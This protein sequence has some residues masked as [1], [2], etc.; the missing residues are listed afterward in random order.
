MAVDS[1]WMTGQAQLLEMPDCEAKVSVEHPCSRSS[2]NRSG[3]RS[4]KHSTETRQASRILPTKIS[5]T[6]WL[7]ASR[8]TRTI[9]AGER[10]ASSDHGAGPSN[11][12]RLN[13]TYQPRRQFQHIAKVPATPR[14]LW[15]RAVN[16]SIARI[17][18][19]AP[20]PERQQS[21]TL[22]SGRRLAKRR[23]GV[24]YYC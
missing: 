19:A 4:I 10:R 1:P 20:S 24:V 17:L 8:T 2:E 18:D 3:H 14:P 7:L 23:R 5:A 6:L 16:A 22:K 9:G 21:G 12:V 15:S 13:R 11:K